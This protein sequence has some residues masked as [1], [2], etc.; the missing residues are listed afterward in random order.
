MRLKFHNSPKLPRLAWCANIQKGENTVEVLHGPWVETTEHFFCD[1]AWSGDFL[2]GDFDTSLLMGSG[3]R[4]ADDTLII[5][6]PNHT[7]ERIFTLRDGKTLWVSNSLAF[8]LVSNCI[9][10]LKYFLIANP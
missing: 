9:N 6:A 5:A 7:L 8:V 2:C 1:G 4:V 3:G 10:F